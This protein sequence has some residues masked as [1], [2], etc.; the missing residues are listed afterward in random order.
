MR[1]IFRNKTKENQPCPTPVL[2]YLSI[3]YLY[4]SSVSPW[5]ER[6]QELSEGAN[7]WYDEFHAAVIYG[8]YPE[9]KDASQYL[10]QSLKEYIKNN[11]DTLERSRNK[12]IDVIRQ[13]KTKKA[14]QQ[15][16]QEVIQKFN[17]QNSY[18]IYNL[19][20]EQIKRINKNIKQ[21]S[22]DHIEESLSQCSQVLQVLGRALKPE[23]SKT[24]VSAVHFADEIKDIEGYIS[25]KYHITDF[26]S[27]KEVVNQ[28]LEMRDKGI[29]DE[30]FNIK[31]FSKFNA[32]KLVENFAY[33]G[34][35]YD[36]RDK[37]SPP[38]QKAVKSI[39]D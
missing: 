18:D 27:H 17:L 39:T 12:I 33:H 22:N 11:K 14:L 26:S 8:M 32:S 38:Q 23:M 30:K 2:M 35:Y 15:I 36:L 20:E 24:A 34:K 13:R 28:I 4:H 31:D 25:G 37:I 5:Y 21:A 29:L 3:G 16:E 6:I 19:S 9:L 10:K 7:K 1:Q